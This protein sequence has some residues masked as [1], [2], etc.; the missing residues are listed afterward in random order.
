MLL[1]VR[2]FVWS[3]LT[4]PLDNILLTAGKSQDNTQ[5]LW[6][7]KMFIEILYKKSSELSTES[8]PNVSKLH[9]IDY[10]HS[11]YH[12]STRYLRTIYTLS[13]HL[14]VSVVSGVAEGK[15]PDPLL[16]LSVSHPP[17]C[18]APAGRRPRPR[19]RGQGGVE[20]LGDRELDII[21]TH[22]I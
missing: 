8:T 13:S 18:L 16:Q 10:I 5:Y 21:L 9:A 19:H 4:Q 7:N 14:I 2:L 15:G 17:R 11:F 1:E 22:L 3:E 6:V 12:L 20:L